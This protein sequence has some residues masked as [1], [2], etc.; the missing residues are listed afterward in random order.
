[1]PHSKSPMPFTI[2]FGG[3]KKKG[4]I[5]H[6]SNSQKNAAP[7]LDQRALNFSAKEERGKEACG[8]GGSSGTSNL[9]GGVVLKDAGCLC[10]PRKAQFCSEKGKRHVWVINLLG[11]E[12]GQKVL[13]KG[14]F[15][16]I[17]AGGKKR[18][19]KKGAAKQFRIKKR[20]REQLGGS[21]KRKRENVTEARRSRNCTFLSREKGRR[22]KKNNRYYVR[23]RKR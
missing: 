22:G 23:E 8:K 7:I 12:N 17:T 10:S 6:F 15:L 14:N 9:D 18:G 5:Y 13:V 20:K 2:T 16:E 11:G 19:G 3:G 4:E 1:L 21:A